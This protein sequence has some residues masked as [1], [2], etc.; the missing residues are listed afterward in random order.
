MSTIYEWLNK[1]SRAKI[2]V[3]GTSL[4]S[5]VLAE[6]LLNNDLAEIVTFFEASEPGGAWGGR[7]FAVYPKIPKHNNVI[8]P[9]SM[10]QTRSI[11]QV[12]DYLQSYGAKVLPSSLTRGYRNPTDVKILTGQFHPFI[13]QILSL[14]RV[15]LERKRIQS[16]KLVGKRVELDGRPFDFCFISNNSKLD[17][18]ENESDKLSVNMQKSVSD[19]EYETN[20]SYHLRLL[21]D[22]AQV[23]T[24]VP[25]YSETP[26]GAFDRWGS[27]QPDCN[28]SETVVVIGRVSRENKHLSQN[29]LVEK[30]SEIC[31]GTT[32]ILSSEINAFTQSRASRSTLAVYQEFF[33]HSRVFVLENNDFLT[34]LETILEFVGTPKGVVLGQVSF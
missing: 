15:R 9:Y 14:P 18:L 11:T 28:N 23:S 17:Y 4:A 29:D 6:Q 33:K 34:S 7:K 13:D 2:A 27:I 26:S 1:P 21:I 8:V 3:I 24:F 30:T 10:S 16:L 31:G 32:P 22:S 25:S 5:A 19:L 12:A 20:T